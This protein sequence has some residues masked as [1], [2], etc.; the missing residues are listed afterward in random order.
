MPTADKVELEWPDPA[1]LGLWTVVVV[2][3][4]V[5]TLWEGGVPALL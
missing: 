5:D 3:V 2:V 4:V 1:V